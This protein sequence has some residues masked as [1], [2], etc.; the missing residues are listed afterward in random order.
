MVEID[1][2]KVHLGGSG[3]DDDVAAAVRQAPVD[4]LK[5]RAAH[6]IEGKIDASPGAV[7]RGSKGQR[8]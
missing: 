8:P 4:R 2:V 7:T 1:Q 5:E 3:G 6:G